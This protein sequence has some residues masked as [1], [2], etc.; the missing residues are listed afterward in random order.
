MGNTENGYAPKSEEF[1]K[2]LNELPELAEPGMPEWD[3]IEMNPLLD[4]S[5]VAVD[6]WNKIG[7]IIKDNYFKY[8][9]FVVLHGTDTMSY[10]ASALSFMLEGL[11][12][13]VVITGSQ[14]PLCEPEND[15][16]GNIVSAIKVAADN[17][18]CEVCICFGTKLIR[19]NRAI[20]IS[21]DDFEAFSSPNCDYIGEVGDKI[22]Y[23]ENVVLEKT[24][25][26]I[27]LC[28]LNNIPIGLIKIFPGIQFELFDSIMTEK[29][30]GLVIEAFGAGN[31]PSNDGTILPILKKSADNGTVIVVCTQC[32]EGGV[33]LG[34]YEAST[35]LKMAGAVSG[36][37]MTSEAAF[38]KL[39]Y[40]FSKGYSQDK[41][42]GEI[43]K[44]LRGELSNK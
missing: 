15:A 37:D 22:T 4:S 2:L 25:K 5:N 16:K 42:K 7:N 35:P 31:I 29:L 10:T 6:E 43:E 17:K 9:G 21:A 18:V 23:N 36:H 33:S 27:N 34:A 3:I 30:K 11:D 13:P 44:N 12:K 39:H 20:K 19:G 28:S 38:A 32:T 24:R 14:I 1:H 41:I 26:E 40:L 8:H